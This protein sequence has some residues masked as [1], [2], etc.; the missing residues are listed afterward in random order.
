MKANGIVRHVDDLGRVAIPKE[1]RRMFGIA[2][3]DPL[4]IFTDSNGEII[5]RK[6]K[7][8]F[9]HYAEDW[10]SEHIDI[11]NRCEFFTHGDYTFCIVPAG[12]GHARKT[13]CGYS[14]RFYSDKRNVAI[15]Q[16]AAYAK[17][18]GLNLNKMIGYED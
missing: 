11:L 7:R 17:A 6:Y 3:G 9:E 16:V 5:I 10:Y 15:G 8:P 12:L 14:K 18:V 1:I 4:E 2:E 13:C